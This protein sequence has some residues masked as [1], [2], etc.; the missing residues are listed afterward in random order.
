[1][2]DPAML[3]CITVGGQDDNIIAP[4][5]QFSAH[6]LPEKAHKRVTFSYE[7]QSY[8]NGCPIAIMPR[9]ATPRIL[10]QHGMFTVHGADAEP[11]EQV[12][13]TQPR[14]RA[15]IARIDIDPASVDELRATMR[16]LGMSAF[17]VF[18]EVQEIAPHIRATY[19]HLARTP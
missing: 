19:S 1:M 11:L 14:E 2:I 15:L 17:A 8:D 13:A 4:V 18:P 3:N 12:F 5:G 9:R 7:D 10:A 16:L 6:W